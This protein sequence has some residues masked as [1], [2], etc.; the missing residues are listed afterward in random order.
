LLQVTHFANSMLSIDNPTSW[1]RTNLELISRLATNTSATGSVAPSPGS[2]HTA[3]GGIAGGTVGG[4]VGLTVVVG[5]ITLL[6]R[7]RKRRPGQEFGSAN[8]PNE[9]YPMEGKEQQASLQEMDQSFA[10]PAELSEAGM[11]EMESRQVSVSGL[12]DGRRD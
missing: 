12:G 9:I 2:S 6:I 5:C 1:G 4:V 8:L 3:T 11:F 7:R 10:R